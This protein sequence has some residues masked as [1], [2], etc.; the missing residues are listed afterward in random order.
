[1]FNRIPLLPPETQHI[2][3]TTPKIKLNLK[4]F[5][6]TDTMNYGIASKKEGISIWNLIYKT[7]PTGLLEQFPRTS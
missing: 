2:K 6:L 7:F 4:M 1:M 3:S 5:I